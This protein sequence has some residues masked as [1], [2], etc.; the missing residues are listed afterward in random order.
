MLAVSTWKTKST[1]GVAAGARALSQIDGV[2]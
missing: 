1:D 2:R